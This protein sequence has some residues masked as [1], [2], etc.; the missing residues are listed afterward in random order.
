M[1]GCASNYKIVP[2]ETLS[3][4]SQ[5]KLP[6]NRLICIQ[7]SYSKNI[8]A[9]ASNKSMIKLM[10]KSQNSILTYG[11]SSHHVD[12]TPIKIY[13]ESS[14]GYR[15]NDQGIEYRVPQLES[16]ASSSLIKRRIQQKSQD[17]LSMSS[18]A[19][20]KPNIL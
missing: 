2:V 16:V 3:N 9:K 5:P 17:K 4:L 13:S 19:A 6:P 11:S 18:L 10:P 12:L 8:Y 14:L 1:G 15:V 20:P 7:K